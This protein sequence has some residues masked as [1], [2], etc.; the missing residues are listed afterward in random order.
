[1]SWVEF[2]WGHVDS[3]REKESWVLNFIAL[4]KWRDQEFLV[5]GWT[6]KLKKKKK[7]ST[8]TVQVMKALNMKLTSISSC[9]SDDSLNS[10]WSDQSLCRCSSLPLI[11]FCFVCV[12][13]WS[14]FFTYTLIPLLLHGFTSDFSFYMDLL[15][16][17]FII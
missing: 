3:W 10:P 17:S 14:Q 13:D 16:S 2:T 4:A 12:F 9:S 8:E 5:T 6:E 7:S 11:Q 1:M 15:E